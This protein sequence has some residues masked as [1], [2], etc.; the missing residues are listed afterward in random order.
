V[1]KSFGQISQEENGD[2]ALIPQEQVL[3]EEDFRKIGGQEPLSKSGAARA[4]SVRPAL[5]G[6][7]RQM[8]ATAAL[9]RFLAADIAGYSRLMEAEKAGTRIPCDDA[10]RRRCS[11]PRLDLAHHRAAEDQTVAVL[12][13][14]LERS[15]QNWSYYGIVKTTIFLPTEHLRKRVQLKRF[16]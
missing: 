7:R 16:I 15:L 10:R 14:P 12:N 5:G 6:W 3:F 13:F 1:A 8:T 4:L 11:W 9:P 2:H